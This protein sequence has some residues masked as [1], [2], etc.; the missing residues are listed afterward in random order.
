[1]ATVNSGSMNDFGSFASNA[2]AAQR[3]KQKQQA[4]AFGVPNSTSRQAATGVN[5]GGTGYTSGQVDPSQTISALGAATTAAAPSAAPPPPVPN[6]TTGFRGTGGSTGTTSAQPVQ[7]GFRG[8]P[9]NDVQ[10]VQSSLGT[11]TSAPPPKSVGF[12]SVA[13]PINSAGLG[14]SSPAANGSAG[15]TDPNTGTYTRPATLSTGN[16]G[17]DRALDPGG[18]FTGA[19]M[20]DVG[21]AIASQ[22]A[23]FG[24]S[25][26]LGTE[27]YNYRPGEAAAQD[28]V[29]L[30]QQQANETRA[31]QTQA[32]DALT[33]AANGTVES[34]A[35]LQMRQEAG[36]SVAA[37][38]GQAR[39]LGGRSAGGAARAGTLASADILAK[40]NA[41][42]ATLRASET[43]NARNQLTAALGGVRG[44]DVE[45]AAKNADLNQAANA[46]NLNSQLQQNELAEKQRQALIDAQ[47]KALGIGT[48]ASSSILNAGAAN[49]NADNKQKGGILDTVGNLL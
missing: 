45:T 18:I 4:D 3:Q 19:T 1:M 12:G 40:N 33:A 36:R 37:T 39:A 47:L 48:Q 17:V 14:I 23:A 9:D 30:D 28:R 8:T 25:D 21:P 6:A 46:N 13:A 32:L 26:N 5:P 27:R 42:A 20:T 11:P 43:A 10:T 41:D 31:R 29:A 34:P 24:L 35:E 15:T 22:K 7:T 2:L 44:Q 38:L 49:A 16:A